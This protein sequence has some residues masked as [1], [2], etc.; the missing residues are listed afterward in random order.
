ML[1]AKSME[2]GWKLDFAAIARSWRGGCIIR[3]VFLDKIAEAYTAQPDLPHLLFAP[4][5]AVRYI[6]WHI[7]VRHRSRSVRH[8]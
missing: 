8:R 5:F 3:S 2:A 7:I 6:L 1:K 4:F